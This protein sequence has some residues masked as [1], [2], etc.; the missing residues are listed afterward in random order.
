MSKQLEIKTL[1]AEVERLEKGIKKEK[2][3]GLV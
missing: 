1:K 3:Y 2:K